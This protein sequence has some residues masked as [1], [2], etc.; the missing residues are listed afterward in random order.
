MEI[1]LNDQ[2]NRVTPFSVAFTKD[3]RLIGE[4]TQNQAAINPSPT[5]FDVKLLVSAP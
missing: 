5:I 2:G 1:I 3:E 4:A